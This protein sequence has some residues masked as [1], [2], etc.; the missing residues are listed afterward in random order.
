MAV[1]TLAVIGAGASLGSVA[2]QRNNAKKA[3]AQ[4]EQAMQL[5]LA[6]ARRSQEEQLKVQRESLAAQKELKM[7]EIQ[8]QKDSLTAQ[9]NAAKDQQA[10]QIKANA[11]AA[12]A[13]ELTAVSARTQAQNTG[14]SPN[15]TMTGP[16]GSGSSLL[17]PVRQ[18]TASSTINDLLAAVMATK[19]AQT[20]TMIGAPNQQVATASPGI[21][22]LSTTSIVVGGAAIVGVALLIA[23]AKRRK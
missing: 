9:L 2:V 4:N 14:I 6:E 13:A 23:S 17:Q 16:M 12:A 5:Q 11:D 3:L 20:S 7:A 22:G 10:A 21:L 18:P 15:T 1:T 19:Q 8:A